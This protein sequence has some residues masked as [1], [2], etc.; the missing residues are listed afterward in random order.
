MAHIWNFHSNISAERTT[1]TVVQWR[2]RGQ[3]DANVAGADMKISGFA[4]FV[5]VALVLLSPAHLSTFPNLAS[6]FFSNLH[7]P[8]VALAVV[9][10]REVLKRHGSGWSQL[11]HCSA[12]THRMSNYRWW[13]REAVQRFPWMHA[14]HQAG[15]GIGGSDQGAADADRKL[16]RAPDGHVR[17]HRQVFFI[18]PFVFHLH[19]GQLCKYKRALH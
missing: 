5:R 10:F 8:H 4:L 3:T 12:F 19:L 15:R 11:T 16:Q 14:P 13:M 2:F 7:G 9:F 6:I 18:Q 1:C 17:N